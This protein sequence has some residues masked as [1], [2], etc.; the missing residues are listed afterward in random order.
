M[1]QAV[2]TIDDLASKNT[3]AIVDYLNEKQIQVVMFLV[4]E[5]VEKNK[6]EA[7]YALQHGMIL[8]NHSFTH[9]Y[10]SKLSYEEGIEEIEKCE[11]VLD[12]LYKEAGVE[13]K[14]RPFR[15]PFGDRGG[16]NTEK[17]QQY[18]K[19]KGF[20]KLK[21]SQITVSWWK[22]DRHHEFVDTFWTFD[23][24]EYR[25][26]WDPD[27]TYEKIF[28]KINNTNPENGTVLLEEGSRHLLLLHAHDNTE[29]L[30]PE[31]YKQFI[32]YLLEKDVQFEKPEFFE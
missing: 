29:A 22:E 18:F 3:P 4:G 19:E 7:I 1:I 14:Y 28:E 23:F 31:Y 2:L 32:D 16:D 25:L 30:I 9:P 21:D 15:F 12:E 13:R 11:T 26:N 17:Y 6:S 27:F 24:E 10:F 5:S 8:G 20:H